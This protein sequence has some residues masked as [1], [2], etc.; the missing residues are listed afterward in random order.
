MT[1]VQDD[2]KGHEAF[3]LH[4]LLD[5]QFTAGDFSTFNIVYNVYDGEPI[6]IGDRPTLSD[7]RQPSP[8]RN[9][10]ETRARN[11]RPTSRAPTDDE[12]MEVDS[13]SNPNS[14]IHSSASNEGSSQEKTVKDFLKA[15]FPT[16]KNTRTKI[17][18]QIQTM[19]TDHSGMF[20]AF[21]T[22]I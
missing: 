20:E 8:P 16:D 1:K 14:S 3:N 10:D 11:S 18:P 6:N 15:C 7:L 5:N 19:F 4:S 2:L 17:E 21:R 12:K 9:S 22:L 13:N